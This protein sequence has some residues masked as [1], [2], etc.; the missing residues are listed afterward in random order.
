MRTAPEIPAAGLR[1]PDESGP[2]ADRGHRDPLAALGAFLQRSGLK[3]SRQ[4]EAI[5]Q[6]FFEMGGHV[7]VEA[8]VARVREQDPRVSVATVYRTMKL[9]AECGLAVPRR[10]G[11]GQ[12]RYEPADRRHGDAHDHLICTSCGAILEFESERISEL[13]R[14]VARRHGFEVERRRVE[15]YGRCA[16]CRR[17]AGEEPT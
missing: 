16:G 10:F 5:A 1:R 7:P 8:L 9:L 13:Q 14:R 11:D 3:H 4:R 6:T 15:L 17:G 12:T 2:R